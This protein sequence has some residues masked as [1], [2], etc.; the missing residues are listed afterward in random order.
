MTIITVQRLQAAL[1]PWVEFAA[2]Y[3]DPEARERTLRSAL[4]SMT[5]WT[6]PLTDGQRLA[7]TSATENGMPPEAALQAIHDINRS[8]IAD[9]EVVDVTGVRRLEEFKAELDDALADFPSAAELVRDAQ[10]DGVALYR[11]HP[12]VGG[13]GVPQLP[14]GGET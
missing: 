9:S 5:M 1:E 6:T 10:R 4:V 8:N 11:V 13:N 7:L 3:D 14:E 2:S 12:P